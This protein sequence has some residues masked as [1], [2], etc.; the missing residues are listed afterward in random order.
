VK[1]LLRR[2][3]MVTAASFAFGAGEAQADVPIGEFELGVSGST[4]Q[5]KLVS[6]NTVFLRVTDKLI[7]ARKTAEL[8]DNSGRQS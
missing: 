4:L 3:I 5:E 8:P 7:H 2:L 1:Q 6:Q